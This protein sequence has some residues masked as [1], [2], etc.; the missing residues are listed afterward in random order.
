MAHGK[1]DK[2]NSGTVSP[3]EVIISAASDKRDVICSRT[4]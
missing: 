1:M 4:I 3:R 2:Q